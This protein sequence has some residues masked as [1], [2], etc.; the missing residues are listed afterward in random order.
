MILKWIKWRFFIRIKQKYCD[1]KIAFL[2]NNRKTI[3]FI[4]IMW[5]IVRFIITYLLNY[6]FVSELVNSNIYM[7]LMIIFIMLSSLWDGI[8]TENNYLTSIDKEWLK[9]NLVRDDFKVKLIVFFENILFKAWNI[10]AIIFGCILPI[11]YRCS[12]NF[13]KSIFI[14]ILL[15]GIYFINSLIIA[16]INDL[17]T[18]IK[19]GYIHNY[20]RMGISVVLKAIIFY[21]TYIFAGKLYKYLNNVFL[22][23]NKNDIEYFNVLKDDCI[24]KFGK[25]ISLL[26]SSW[27]TYEKAMYCCIFFLIAIIC[28]KIIA[29][30]ERKYKLYSFTKC[31]H[32]S[33]I[34][35]MVIFFKNKGI[36]KDEIFVVY[37]KLFLR[38]FFT[39][40]NISCLTGN[41]GYWM[42]ISFICALIVHA[43][44]VI[45]YHCLITIL[46]F[47]PIYN[48]GNYIYEKFF[49]SVSFESDG[50]KVYIQLISKQTLWDIFNRKIKLF[51][52]IFFPI[53]FLGDIIIF[54]ITKMKFVYILGILIIHIC[55]IIFYTH[56]YYIPGAI[57]PHFNFSDIQQL[58]SYKDKEVVKETING[59]I[60]MCINP[61]MLLPVVFFVTNNIN[62]SLFICIQAII[63]ILLLICLTFIIRKVLKN[64]LFNTRIIDLDL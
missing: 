63:P 62:T 38:N 54:F 47:K 49:P 9:A 30:I 35:K 14:S 48:L 12:Q 55:M 6:Y 20:F 18:C 29:I 10:V 53:I 50:K 56:V 64:K 11:N 36:I 34:E 46:I 25:V 7:N 60:H 8:L 59:F 13:S 2:K 51:M 61:L 43:D 17:Y 19:N 40:K 41:I 16:Y 23:I 39:L 37:V 3:F 32:L 58:L 42:D 1:S 22:M 52:H 4:T 26:E 24:K 44:N 31:K 45:L 28:I 27:F 5:K 57:A 33:N 21:I 15:L